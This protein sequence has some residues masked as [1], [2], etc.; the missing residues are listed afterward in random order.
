M[1]NVKTYEN[2]LNENVSGKKIFLIAVDVKD[3]SRNIEDHY[4]RKIIASD[5]E[6]AK[7]MMYDEITK[8]YDMD[9][10]D[11]EDMMAFISEINTTDTIE[12]FG[13]GY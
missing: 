1:K 3:Q 2:F 4:F 12:K 9:F 7:Q 10:E 13:S 6:E 8:E 11:F 5:E